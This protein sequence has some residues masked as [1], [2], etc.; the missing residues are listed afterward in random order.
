MKS[1]SLRQLNVS[2]AE[3]KRITYNKESA[4]IF[5]KKKSKDSMETFKRYSSIYDQFNNIKDYESEISVLEN[6]IDFKIINKCLEIG[7]GTGTYASHVS[8]LLKLNNSMKTDTHMTLVD[9]SSSMLQV[10]KKKQYFVSTDFIINDFLSIS[11]NSPKLFANYDLIYS[12]F[13]VVSY[14]PDSQL[15]FILNSVA[16]NQKSGSYFVFDFWDS[17]AVQLHPPSKSERTIQGFNRIFRK[18]QIKKSKSRLKRIAYPKQIY[19]SLHSSLAYEINFVFFDIGKIT[20]K[21]I[22][23]ETHCMYAHRYH[24]IREILKPF[25]KIIASLDLVTG[26]DYSGKSY[27]RTL[28]LERL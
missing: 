26:D 22:F 18:R 24:E 13:H 16:Q 11:M 2:I 12:L 20:Q 9:P 6:Y 21:K 28:I 10:A 4:I 8:K 3:G 27:G 14:I 15:Y 19:S 25:Y 7:A 1:F 17:M 5:L 23:E